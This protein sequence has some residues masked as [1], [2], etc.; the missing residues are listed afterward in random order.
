MISVVG[1]GSSPS[2]H[3]LSLLITLVAFPLFVPIKTPFTQRMEMFASQKRYSYNYLYIEK[4]G[5]YQIKDK[6]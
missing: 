5:I 3:V 2:P 1:G 6:R 4:T